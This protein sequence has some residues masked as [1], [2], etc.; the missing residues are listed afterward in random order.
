MQPAEQF[1]TNRTL[2]PDVASGL[3]W[4]LLMV[5]GRNALVTVVAG[6]AL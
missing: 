3:D 2:L 4:T 1:L 6:L 5:G